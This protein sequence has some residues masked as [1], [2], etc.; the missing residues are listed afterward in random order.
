MPPKGLCGQSGDGHL[1][2]Q[3]DGV[4]AP[5]LGLHTS[6]PLMLPVSQDH[7]D[8]GITEMEE[9]KLLGGKGNIDG[10][11]SKR[12]FG[13]TRLAVQNA[14]LLELIR[15]ETVCGCLANKASYI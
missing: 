14:V 5:P 1:D 4:Q 7:R 11:S 12:G 9:C 15:L 13:L 2:R 6:L 8:G 10:E 3:V